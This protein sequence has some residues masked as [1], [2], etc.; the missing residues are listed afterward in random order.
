MKYL[1][2]QIKEKYLYYEAGH[3]GGGS[4]RQLSGVGRLRLL[5]ASEVSDDISSHSLRTRSVSVAALLKRYSPSPDYLLRLLSHIP[6]LASSN[7]IIPAVRKSSTLYDY[8][9]G[10]Q[11]GS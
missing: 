8:V 7:Q 2:T 9:Q 6:A 1:L 11:V 10:D 3:G 5:L 4:L